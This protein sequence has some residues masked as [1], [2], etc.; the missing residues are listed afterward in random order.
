MNLIRESIGHQ[1]VD[2]VDR[3]ILLDNIQHFDA[4]V[5]VITSFFDAT[6]F[7]ETNYLEHTQTYSTTSLVPTFGQIKKYFVGQTNSELIDNVIYDYPF[8]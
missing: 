7:A 1:T 8:I 5:K 2:C 4:E 6:A 3:D